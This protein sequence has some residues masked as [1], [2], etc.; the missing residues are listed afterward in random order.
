VLL[1]NGKLTGSFERSGDTPIDTEAVHAAF[2][3]RN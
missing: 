3:G 1:S 2:A